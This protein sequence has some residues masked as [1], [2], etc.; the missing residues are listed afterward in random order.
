[1][2]FLQP[3]FRLIAGITVLVW[4]LYCLT[5]SANANPVERIAS[6][7]P[8]TPESH[9]P[10]FTAREWQWWTDGEDRVYTNGYDEPD[11]YPV[12]RPHFDLDNSPVINHYLDPL[13]FRP[14]EGW[15]LFHKNL[16]TPQQKVNLPYFILYNK[17]RGILRIYFWRRPNT[18]NKAN[19][20]RWEVVIAGNSAAVFTH[21]ADEYHS[22]IDTYDPQLVLRVNVPIA[23]GWCFAE[24]NVSGFDADALERSPVPFLVFDYSEY[25]SQTFIPE[26]STEQYLLESI[27]VLIQA[28]QIYL[29]GYATVPPPTVDNYPIEYPAYN[30]PLG[31]Y[32]LSRFRLDAS[33]L[34][35]FSL[36]QPQKRINTQVEWTTGPLHYRINPAAGIRIISAEYS[37]E[38]ITELAPGSSEYYA[39]IHRVPVT[40]AAPYRFDTGLSGPTQ[41]TDVNPEDQTIAVTVTFVYVPETLDASVPP[42]SPMRQ[43]LRL[44]KTY[45][46]PYTAQQSRAFAL[47]PAGACLTLHTYPNPAAALTTVAYQLPAGAFVRLHV[48]DA[49]GREVAR[50]VDEE[51]SQG[52]HS[53]VFNTAHLSNG[54]YYFQLRTDSQSVTQKVLVKR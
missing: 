38:S 24:I 4:Q 41:L 18:I 3:P 51:K 29:P 44:T 5:P 26:G 7:H 35:Q 50:L 11:G 22:F 52:Y 2:E 28:F 19:V 14:E 46:V 49:T 13:D 45:R 32:N 27:P 36:C 8:A 21:Y 10:A 53:V 23:S 15:N 30:H 12:K 43:G 39:R 1:M 37:V 31:L 54:L 9:A 40:S 20:G 17:Y 33:L 48:Y 16:G 34:D 25:T 42:D 6:V 47:D